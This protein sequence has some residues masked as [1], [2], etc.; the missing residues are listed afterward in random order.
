[1]FPNE[2]YN[3]N[4]LIISDSY[5]ISVLVSVFLMISLLSTSL[6]AANNKNSLNGNIA[7][8]DLMELS[9][10]ELA[11]VKII[12]PAAITKLSFVEIPASITVITAEDIRHTPARNILDLIEAYVPGA[13]WMNYEEGPLLGMRG[14]IVNRNYK[15]LLRV[16]GRLMNGKDRFSAKSELEQWDLGDIKQIEVIRGPGSVTYGPGAVSGVVNILTHSADSAPGLQ[17]SSKIIDQYNSRGL[18]LS[19]GKNINNIKLYSFASITKT[20][21]DSSPH[22]IGNNNNEAGYIGKDIFLDS[23]ALDYFADYHDQPQMKY[24][25]STNYKDKLK[26]WVRYTQQGSTW[27]G[28]EAKSLFNGKLVNQQAVRDRQITG[29]LEYFHSINQNI[30]LSSMFSIDSFDVERRKDQI[31]ATD[32]SDVKNF[33]YNYSETEIFFRSVLNW[34]ISNSNEIALGMEFSHDKFGPGWGESP[35]EMRL[36]EDGVI[37]NNADSNALG[38]DSLNT[39]RAIYAGNGWNSNTFSLFGEANLSLSP[40]Y[41]LLVSSRFDKNSFTDWLISPR[42][43]LITKLN[44]N[45][46]LKIIAQ[47]SQR[48]ESAGQLFVDDQTGIT[49]K[50]E[51]LN[52]LELALNG[53]LTKKLTLKIAG[54]LNDADVNAWNGDGNAEFFVGKLKTYGIE[55]EIFFKNQITTVGA[56]YS[57]VKQ[58]SWDLDNDLSG[59]SISYSEYNQPLRNSNA[60][61]LSE[62]NDLNNWANQSIKFF[63]RRKIS[64]RLTLHM[65]ARMMWDFQG[66]KDGLNSLENAVQGEPEEIAVE[67]TLALVR[68]KNVYEYDFRVNASI[69]FQIKKSFDIQVF[70]Q[71][72]LS[73][74]NNKRYSFDSGNDRAAPKR[75][76][77]VEE[78]R[79]FGIQFRYHLI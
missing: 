13:M 55:N 20:Q 21:G 12:V 3:S 75:V 66:A 29:T 44:T 31:V 71:N 57:L 6:L 22:F 58:I 69:N 7:I 14:N 4:T 35:S 49:P 70:T 79:T 38:S 68:D 8:D 43:A 19:Y 25:V 34:N 37:V 78:P 60:T 39:S 16:N 50:N 42:I 61:M 62:G 51:T 11:N 64:N 30:N 5:L 63:T 77:F 26:T 45:Y 52:S 72:I 65:D 23:E 67:N 40:R 56:S 73:S 15:Y 32:L 48:M 41:K 2:R 54:F 46:Y 53:K 76:R 9:I 59:S 18:S 28:N 1:M 47:R 24:F 10:D 74:N 33:K 27:R 17:V 36:G